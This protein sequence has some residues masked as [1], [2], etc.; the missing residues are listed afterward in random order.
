MGTAE[1]PSELQVTEIN[2]V[3]LPQMERSS[4]AFVHRFR[5]RST[6]FLRSQSEVPGESMTTYIGWIDEYLPA[7]SLTRS[8]THSFAHLSTSI[9]YHKTICHPTQQPHYPITSRRVTSPH[10]Q[11]LACIVHSM[12]RLRCVSHCIL[13]SRMETGAWLIKRV[14]KSFCEPEHKVPLNEMVD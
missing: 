11:I 6:Y 13:M 2:S 12:Q 10:E 1:T 7:H 14:R 9:T 4:Q 3:F 5:T 8:L